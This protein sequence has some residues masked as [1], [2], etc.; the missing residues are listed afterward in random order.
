MGP[1]RRPAVRLASFLFRYCPVLECSVADTRGRFE[2][3][4]HAQDMTDARNC[5]AE[6][7][8]VNAKTS[9]GG[10]INS[11]SLAHVQLSREFGERAT[12]YARCEPL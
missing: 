3:V 5:D 7:I 1:I 8:D 4:R 11:P 9:R 12:I 6:K 10:N 2:N